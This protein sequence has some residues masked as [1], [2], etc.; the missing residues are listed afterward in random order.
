M[1]S[2]HVT[3]FILFY[4]IGRTLCFFFFSFLLHLHSS[5]HWHPRM[6][7]CLC[8]FVI[9]VSHGLHWCMLFD[10]YLWGVCLFFGSLGDRSL[11]LRPFLG[12]PRSHHFNEEHRPS[13]SL[14]CILWS[15]S[16]LSGCAPLCTMLCCA[17]FLWL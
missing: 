5:C 3:Y 16:C 9:E 17:V 2:N 13:P 11:P 12:C 1:I 10:F 15:D 14:S 7:S 8:E 6:L 4:S